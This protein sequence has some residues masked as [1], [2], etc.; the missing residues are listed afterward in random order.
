MTT[1]DIEMVQTDAEVELVPVET[2][3]YGLSTL[4]PYQ[5]VEVIGGNTDSQK[6]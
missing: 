1:A 3:Q 6:G 5:G 2:I 4:T